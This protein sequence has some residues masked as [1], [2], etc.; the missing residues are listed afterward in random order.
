MQVVPSEYLMK[1]NSRFDLPK[2]D[3]FFCCFAPSKFGAYSPAVL[4][5]T[6][7]LPHPV[8]REKHYSMRNKS[9]LQHNFCK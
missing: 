6:H 2:L 5:H 7:R 9:E 1:V 8:I 3:P 4:F